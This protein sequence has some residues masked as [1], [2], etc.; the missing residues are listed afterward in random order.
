MWLHRLRRDVLG[1]HILLILHDKI[2]MRAQ[3]EH[4]MNEPTCQNLLLSRGWMLGAR[5]PGKELTI[6]PSDAAS[7][8][9]SPRV[10]R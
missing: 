5:T 4:S 9:A 10:L 6:D 2:T 3:E 7:L 8:V 1:R